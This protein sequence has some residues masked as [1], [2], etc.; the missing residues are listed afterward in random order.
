MRTALFLLALLSLSGCEKKQ[1]TIVVEK[2]KVIQLY[3]GGK[4]VAVFTIE[5]I[6]SFGGTHTVVFK[7]MD[8]S[9]I[10]WHGSYMLQTIDGSKPMK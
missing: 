6:G 2:L 8:G 9:W 3:D 1:E 5:D 7:T 4:Q 10:Q